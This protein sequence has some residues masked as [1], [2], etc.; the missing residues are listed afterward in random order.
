MSQTRQR[1][2]W[3]LECHDDVNFINSSALVPL[4]IYQVLRGN[5]A[6]TILDFV[7]A[8]VYVFTVCVG[9]LAAESLF[10]VTWLKLFY[11]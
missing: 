10:T 4:K 1:Q 3:L 9:A 11:S 6:K 7:C 5:E 8:S 2:R